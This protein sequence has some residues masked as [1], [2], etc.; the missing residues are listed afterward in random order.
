MKGWE[1]TTSWTIIRLSLFHG[2]SSDIDIFVPIWLI[3]ITVQIHGFQVLSLHSMKPEL[4]T[5]LS[6]SAH[7]S[8]TEWDTHLLHRFMWT[9]GCAQLAEPLPPKLRTKNEDMLRYSVNQAVTIQQGQQTTW[10]FLLLVWILYY[11]WFI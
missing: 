4:L 9:R 8:S 3:R 6:Q 1:L 10:P 7:S 11:S 5:W 2:V